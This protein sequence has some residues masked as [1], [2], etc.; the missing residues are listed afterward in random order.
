LL[1]DAGSSARGPLIRGRLTYAPPVFEK[2]ARQATAGIDGLR[3]EPPGSGN[4][5]ERFL[6][7]MP[8]L[9]AGRGRRR[10][11][12]S[13]QVAWGWRIP[14][15]ARRA[16]AAVAREIQRLTHYDRVTVN[17]HVSGTF[18]PDEDRGP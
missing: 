14:E 9:P 15:L 6:L 3:M 13:V 12:L 1:G 17:V 7:W 18:N 11:E 16:Q 2:I 10:Q 5:L 4:L 8:R